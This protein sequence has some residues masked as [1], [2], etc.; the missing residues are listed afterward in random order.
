MQ[1]KEGDQESDGGKESRLFERGGKKIKNSAVLSSSK[2]ADQ[3]KP[4]KTQREERFLGR[5]K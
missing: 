3:Q 5:T 2:M 4:E 1:Y